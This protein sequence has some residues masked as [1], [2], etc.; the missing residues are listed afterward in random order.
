MYKHK[1]LL[2]YWS[3]FGLE[4]TSKLYTHIKN[5]SC[6]VCALDMEQYL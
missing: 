6:T 4:I 1:I 2:Y 3:Y 5:S